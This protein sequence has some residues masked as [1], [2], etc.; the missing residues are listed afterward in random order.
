MSKR[1]YLLLI[2]LILPVILTGCWDLQDIDQRAIVIAIAIDFEDITPGSGNI[3]EQMIKLTAQLAIPQKLGAGAGQAP[4]MGEESVWN[5]SAVGRN[6]SMALVNLQQKLQ[7]EIFLAHVRVVVISEDIARDGINRYMNFFK[8]NTEFR[9]LSYFVISEG[10]AEDVLKSFPKTATIQG[11]FLS[12]MIDNEVMR[13]TMPDIPFIEFTIR[14]VNKGIDPVAVMVNSLGDVIK[15]SGLAVFRGDRM[16]GKLEKEEDWNF[17]QLAENYTGGIEVIRDVRSELG[18]IT[19]LFTNIDTH[20]KPVK[21][22]K[23]FL[24]KS[25]ISLEGILISQ[26]SDTDYDNDILFREMEKRIANEVKREMEAVFYKVQH[27]YDADIFGFGE[28]VQAHLP[29]EWN[30]V[31]NWREEFKKLE[32][33]ISVEVKIR[34]VGMHM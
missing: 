23:N 16:V 10:K 4:G 17:I 7:N 32:I 30:K 26:E 8:N 5:V 29:S 31:K 9:R 19:I 6:I 18:R 3:Y 28:R 12:Q 22:E 15:Y 21:K 25:D 13:Q 14:S 20:I 27:Q 33:E 34:R 24:F 11:M 1:L 2:F